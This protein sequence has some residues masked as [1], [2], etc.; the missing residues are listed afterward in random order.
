MIVLYIVLYWAVYYL[1]VGGMLR[2]HCPEDRFFE[3]GLKLS[4]SEG[5]TLDARLLGN[6]STIFSYFGNYFPQ[7]AIYRFF[8]ILLDRFDNRRT[9]GPF[10]GLTLSNVRLSRPK[11]LIFLQKT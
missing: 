11:G 1:V 9:L 6:V 7:L 10:A 3:R 5:K 8:P 4:L 2:L